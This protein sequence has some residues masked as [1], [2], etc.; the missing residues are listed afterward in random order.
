MKNTCR[1]PRDC[2]CGGK[3]MKLFS[4]TAIVLLAGVAVFIL[5]GKESFVVRLLTC[6]LPPCVLIG[7][8]WYTHRRSHRLTARDRALCAAQD[9]PLWLP[10]SPEEIT[11]MNEELGHQGSLCAHLVCLAVLFVVTL[12]LYGSVGAQALYGALC[13]LGFA[14]AATAVVLHH[15]QTQ[16]WQQNLA[17]ASV[18]TLPVSDIFTVVDYVRGGKMETRY[19]V[20]LYR[21]R[22][23]IYALS[24]AYPH[25]KRLAVFSLGRFCRMLPADGTWE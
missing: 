6:L 4:I 9:D 3:F 19:A 20:V 12:L 24:S 17:E 23:F 10:V 1:M 22:K 14:V 21:G 8:V 7:G 25:T 2:F 11:R 15:L 16:L 18:C 13:W 5:C